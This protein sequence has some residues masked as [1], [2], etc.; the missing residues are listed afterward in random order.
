MHIL[1]D[2]AKKIEH[3]F[4]RD[5]F[6]FCFLNRTSVVHSKA[7]KLFDKNAAPILHL[8]G[9]EITLVKVNK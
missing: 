9:V 2:L 5:L 1:N 4:I 6:C 3:P 7:I 8:A